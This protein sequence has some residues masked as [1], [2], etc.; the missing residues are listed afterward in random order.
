M[1]EKEQWMKTKIQWWSMRVV[2]GIP[3]MDGTSCNS[4]GGSYIISYESLSAEQE[5]TYLYKSEYVQ[6]FVFRL[7]MP[8]STLRGKLENL[9]LTYE[10]YQFYSI[11]FHSINADASSTAIATNSRRQK[12]IF[13]VR[14]SVFWRSEQCSSFL[15]RSLS[16]ETSLFQPL[17]A[18]PIYCKQK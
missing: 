7:T 17:Q 9:K 11:R 16:S 10:Q 1:H 2:W 14:Y 13:E 15:S 18:I 5:R 8:S 4:E 12:L 6:V 3:W